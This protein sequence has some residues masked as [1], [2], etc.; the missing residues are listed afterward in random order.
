MSLRSPVQ[1]D[2]EIRS[3][4]GQTW[5]FNQEMD[6]VEH[7]YR[8]GQEI[9]AGRPVK[10]SLENHLNFIYREH[11]SLNS[12]EAIGLSALLGSTLID[13]YFRIANGNTQVNAAELRALPLPPL[14]VIQEIGKQAGKGAYVDLQ[15]SN[16]IVYNVLRQAGY[17]P[18]HLPKITKSRLAMGKIQDAQDILKTLGL[19]LRQQNEQAALTLLVLA[20]LSEDTPWRQ[21][22][23]KSLRIHDILVEIG[24]RFNRI[25]AENTRETVRRQVIHQFIQA[26]IVVRNPDNPVLPTNSPRTHYALSE[27]LLTTIRHYDTAEWPEAVKDFLGYRGLAGRYTRPSDS[28]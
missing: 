22:R 21:A 6:I 17:L 9:L 16:D 8:L 20:Q 1:P 11:G 18:A 25:Y 2:R 3:R 28:F 27:A 14:D 19:P 5:C 26:H 23:R 10:T 24:E 15:R 7:S 13:R 12:E 4:T